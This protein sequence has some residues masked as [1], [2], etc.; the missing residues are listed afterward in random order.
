MIKKL[1]GFT[2]KVTTEVT[3]GEKEKTR[4][5]GIGHRGLWS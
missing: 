5:G 4:I 2:L 1:E 3:A